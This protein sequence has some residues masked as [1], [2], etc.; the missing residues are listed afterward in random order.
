[1]TIYEAGAELFG[2]YAEHDCYNSRKDYNKLILISDTPDE[3]R[4]AISCAL[5]T[6]QETGIVKKKETEG[7]EFWIL[8]KKFSASSQA[9]EISSMT[10]KKVH[11]FVTLYTDAQG[12]GGET[13]ECDPLNICERDIEILISSILVLSK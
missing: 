12:L 4:A 11:G 10:A 7:D 1:M 5:D 3:D 13:H 9:V 6:F 8:N 2:W